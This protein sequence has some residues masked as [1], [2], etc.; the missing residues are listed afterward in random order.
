MTRTI[1]LAI[2]TCVFSL[3]LMLTGCG[4]SSMNPMNSGTAAQGTPPTVSAVATQVNGVAPNREQEVQFSEAMDP[5]TINAQSFKVTDSSGNARA[6]S[7]TYD[8]N[9]DT[10]SFLPNP[11]LAANT[12]YTG[13]I[14]TAAASAGG[15]HL[16]SAYTFEFTTRASTD[17]SPLSVD[18]VS[19]AANATCVSASTLITVT[20]NEVPDAATVTAANFAVTGPNGP[21]AVKMGTDVTTT[22]VVLTPA[23][24]LPAGSISVTVNNVA[25]LAGVKMTAPY[26]WS[27]STACG[28]GGGTGGGGTGGGG[29]GGGG[30]ATTQYQSPLFT[31]VGITLSGSMVGQVTVDTT[32][33][34]TVKLSGATASTT[35]NVQFCP[36]YA[37]ALGITAPPCFD[38]TTVSTDASGNGTAT[39]KFPRPG[40]WAGDFYLNDSAGKTMYE[41]RLS[42]DVKNQTYMA[43]LLQDTTTNGGVVSPYSPQEPLSSGFVSYSNGS[44]QVTVSGALPSTNYVISESISVYL[45]S[46]GT[47]PLG[48]FGTDSSG[49]GTTN[50]QLDFLGGDMIQVEAQNETQAGYIAGFTVPQ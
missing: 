49:D 35:Y 38:V 25:D 12:T 13:T 2:G 33:S 8:S 32:G 48:T 22:Q 28:G 27:F 18:S 24:A 46:S 10:A 31:F 23:S 19:P 36:G 40:D 1:S 41:T 15:A 42:P 26:T 3:P 37:D 39:A 11:A 29:T 14:T 20:F 17:T 30:G 50:A 4:G 45:N 43:K 5:S 47:F 7:V 21:I 34:T 44:L 6:G 9:F 16:A